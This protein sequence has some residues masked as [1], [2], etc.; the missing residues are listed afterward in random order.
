MFHLMFR[1]FAGGGPNT[2]TELRGATVSTR[3]GCASFAL[4]P[5]F[6][7]ALHS[8]LILPIQSLGVNRDAFLIALIAKISPL[9]LRVAN[10]ASVNVHD[11]ARLIIT[12]LRLLQRR[13][14]V[15]RQS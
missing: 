13:K 3:I 11:L 10:Q 5:T 7:T 15:F 6:E 12:T 2:Y 4:P 9:N 8:V 1:R 14:L